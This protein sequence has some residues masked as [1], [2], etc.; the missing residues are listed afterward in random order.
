MGLIMRVRD[1]QELN[2][3]N[4]HKNAGVFFFFFET[5]VQKVLPI[6]KISV[7]ILCMKAYALK[8]SLAGAKISHVHVT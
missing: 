2:L 1:I 3:C 5:Y 8:A 7:N 4:I 6:C